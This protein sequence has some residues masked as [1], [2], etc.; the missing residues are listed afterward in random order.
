MREVWEF[1]IVP[2]TKHS[3]PLHDMRVDASKEVPS[4]FFVRVENIPT[5]VMKGLFYLTLVFIVDCATTGK[6]VR[7]PDSDPTLQDL[8][9]RSAVPRSNEQIH[10]KVWWLPF[11]GNYQASK[12]TVLTA[13][14]QYSTYAFQLI[15][16]K[17]QCDKYRIPISSLKKCQPVAQSSHRVL[18]HVTLAWFERD[19]SSIEMEN[20]C[21]K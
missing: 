8:I 14:K 18:C 7:V 12:V 6:K 10:D 13:G 5:Y 21:S 9:F 4:F 1:N 17:S 2:Y 11:A 19:W 15:L 20:Y 16:Q 3:L